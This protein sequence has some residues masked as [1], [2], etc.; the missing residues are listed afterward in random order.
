MVPVV[1]LV[2]FWLTVG[3]ALTIYFSNKV[4]RYILAEQKKAIHC[5][6]GDFKA[7]GIYEIY[8]ELD[9]KTLC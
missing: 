6:H 4:R 7:E 3:F 5:A 8:K 2:L 9:H 1:N